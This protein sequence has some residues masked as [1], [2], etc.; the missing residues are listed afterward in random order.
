VV[1]F[2]SP[3]A[4]W[5]LA[6][7]EEDKK[8]RRQIRRLPSSRHRNPPLRWRLKLVSRTAERACKCNWDSNRDRGMGL[9][10]HLLMPVLSESFRVQLQ[11]FA[12]LGMAFAQSPRPA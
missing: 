8:E 7:I 12:I 10:F 2:F 5:L 9:S 4:R 6:R 1:R 3:Q 11:T